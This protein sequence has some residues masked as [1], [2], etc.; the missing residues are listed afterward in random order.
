M[1]HDRRKSF[2]LPTLA[3]NEPINVGLKST[4]AIC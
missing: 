1:D 2:R 4:R 3:S